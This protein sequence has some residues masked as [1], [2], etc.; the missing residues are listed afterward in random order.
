MTVDMRGNWTFPTRV[1]FGA[2][3]VGDIG[4]ALK[5]AGSHRPLIVTDAGLKDHEMV[6]RLAGLVSEAG[7]SPTVF[8]E[9]K[10]NPVGRNV[11][12]GAAVLTDA[13]CDSVIAFGGGSAIDAAKGIALMA[14]QDRPLWDFEERPGNWKRANPDGIRPLIAIPT[15]A[16]TGSEVGRSAVIVNEETQTKVIIFHP[17]LLADTVILDPELTLGLPPALTAA[18]GMDALTHCLEAYCVPSFHPMCDGIALNG[19]GLIQRALPRAVDDG[20]DIEARGLMLSAASMGAVAFQKGLGGVHA[21]AHAVGALFDTHHG[22]TNAVILPYMLERNAGVLA[23]RLEP[24]ARILGLARHDVTAVIDFTLELRARI[25]IPDTLAALGVDAGRADTIGDKA[26][27][28]IC[29]L[30]NPQ[31]LDPADYTA[32]FEAAVTGG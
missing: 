6:V 9:V 13:G 8:G 25:G 31:R 14:G 5:S 12:D 3:R 17:R 29:A 27:Q 19:L 2:G 10:G 30:G 1:W 24:V 4:R 22:L 20:A 16:G 15:T 28:D 26:A 32:V 11:T 21:L 18:T 7:G 23:D